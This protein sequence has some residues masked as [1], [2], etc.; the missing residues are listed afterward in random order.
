[1]AKGGIVSKHL[2]QVGV[3]W[4]DASEIKYGFWDSFSAGFYI[5]LL[6]KQTTNV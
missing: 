3:P 2:Q 6:N 1:M 4:G 5:S